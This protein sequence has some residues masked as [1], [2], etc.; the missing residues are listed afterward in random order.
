M[1]QPKKIVYR[2]VRMIEGWPEKI[3]AAQ[4]TVSLTLEG[5]AVPRIR[6]GDEHD[7]W[8]ANEHACHDCAVLKSEFHVLGCD[9]EECP[10]C[11]GQLI[12][13]DCHF[14]QLTNES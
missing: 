8:G 9:G 13:C 4:Q 6:Y 3:S 1:A 12:S 14:D 11:G 7:D 10:S 5:R 2:G